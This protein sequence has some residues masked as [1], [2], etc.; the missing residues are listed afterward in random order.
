MFSQTI[1][2]TNTSTDP[3]E[4]A[5]IEINELTESL[6]L[7]VE[8]N[9]KLQI[10]V[11][12]ITRKNN[13]VQLMSNLSQSEID[14]ILIQNGEAKIRMIKGILEGKQVG[15]YENLLIPSSTEDS[16]N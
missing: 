16:N 6:Q 2:N 4:L 12:G 8:Q 10:I 5:L 9:E 1:N 15:L 3:N 11:M 7:T 13:Q 14:N